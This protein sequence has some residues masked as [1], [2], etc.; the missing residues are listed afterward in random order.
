M[1]LLLSRAD[2][3]LKLIF[4]KKKCVWGGNVSFTFFKKKK[5]KRTLCQ[6]GKKL[7]LQAFWSSYICNF[8]AA[9]SAVGACTIPLK[10][11]LLLSFHAAKP[12]I[13]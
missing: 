4:T 8:A 7:V 3:N 2:E 6:N 5:N 13:K 10:R 1:H 9:S 11:V 12:K